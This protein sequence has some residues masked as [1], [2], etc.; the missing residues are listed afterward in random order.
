[1]ERIVTSF[2]EPAAR[3]TLLVWPTPE[4]TRPTLAALSADDVI[5]HTPG[6]EPD[7]ESA[8]AAVVVDRHGRNALVE[9]VPVDPTATA[10]ASRPFWADL[11]DASEPAPATAPTTPRA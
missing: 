4:H 8:H 5:D 2:S 3:V 7:P 1:M 6:T 11:I 9:H 10:P